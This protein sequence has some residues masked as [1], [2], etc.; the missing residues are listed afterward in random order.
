MN[1]YPALASRIRESLS[2]LEPVAA[3]AVS[4]AE[5]GVVTGDDG[6]WDGVALNLHGFYTGVEHIF[7]DI[8][9]T[10]DDSV[11]EGT[12]WHRDLLMQM[13]AEL[14]NRRPAVVARDTR[15]CLDEFRGF[16]HVVRN[17]YT[18]Q[19]R[20]SRMQE[21]VAEL[22][23]CQELVARDLAAFALFLE[24]IGSITE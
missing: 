3:R 1:D 20:P 18:V 5:K 23:H 21:L 10:I 15:R 2:E 19:L 8:A 9:R 11:P 16:R 13:A 4:L 24:S 6:Y 17:L 7:E 22:G 12:H 14:A